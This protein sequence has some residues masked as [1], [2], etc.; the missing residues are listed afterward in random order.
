MKDYLN[1]ELLNK[2]FMSGAFKLDPEVVVEGTKYT[3]FDSAPISIIESLQGKSPLAVYT[4]DKNNHILLFCWESTERNALRPSGC[5]IIKQLKGD[6]FK[7]EEKLI[8]E[9]DGDKITIRPDQLVGD[10]VRV[11]FTGLNNPK[12]LQGKVDTGA[13]I[14][15]LHADNYKINGQQIQFTCK[16]LSN[17]TLTVPLKTQHAVKSPDGGTVYR[18]VVELDVKV[19][20]KLIQGAMFNLNDRS[21]MDQPVLIGQNIL[22]SGKFYVDPAKT[23]TVA[24]GTDWE[25]LNEIAVGVAMFH[26]NPNQQVLKEFYQSMLDS[27]I[28]FNELMRYIRFEVI[29]T[30]E[31]T[32]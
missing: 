28:T 19:N 8:V 27:D 20:G 24:V 22:Q 5:E 14:S 23:E 1:T 11:S 3:L 7:K 17:T 21:H 25:M 2:D 16:P 32:E 18:P 13:T 10:I 4:N 30:F 6:I 15:S 31:D 9:L 12:E 29:Q 26:R